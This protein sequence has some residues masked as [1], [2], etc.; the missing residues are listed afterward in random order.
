M[1]TV[2]FAHATPEHSPVEMAVLNGAGEFDVVAHLSLDTPEARAALT[3]C[4][5]LVV[6][7]HR[8]S[9]EMIATM[10][11][12]KIIA[13]LGTGYDAIDWKAAGERG[14]WVTNVPDYSIDEVSTHA[15]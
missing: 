6:G 11:N 12:C 13:R 9:A 5:A 2:V 8:V 7:L 14:I 10:Q 4:D 3:T 15:L 1:P